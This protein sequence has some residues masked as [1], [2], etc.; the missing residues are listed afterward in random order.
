MSTYLAEETDVSAGR[1]LLAL[2]AAAVE[3]ALTPARALV[4][5]SRARAGV[6]PS[7]LQLAE[8]C[9]PTPEDRWRAGGL[10]RLDPTTIPTT[11]AE[12]ASAAALRLDRQPGRLVTPACRVRG[13]A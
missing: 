9:H 5:A 2:M 10:R 4:D 7:R 8:G 6:T 12:P 13:L 1:E 11:P 3:A